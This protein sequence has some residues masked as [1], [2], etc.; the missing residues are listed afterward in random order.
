MVGVALAL[1]SGWRGAHAAEGP[2][3]GDWLVDADDAEFK[4]IKATDIVLGAKQRIVVPFDTAAKKARDESRFNRLLLLKLDPASLNEKTKAR[5][6]AGGGVLA[7]SA[8][9][10]HQA[11]DVN[12]WRA[13]EQR[14]LCFCHL[15]QFEPAD[16]ATVVSGPAPRPLP[17][18]PLQVDS[19]GR[20]AVAGE[21]SAPLGAI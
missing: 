15:S 4:P 8:I 19:D 6:E 7:Y 14:L 10:T 5:S 11:C 21:F 18:L 12:A 9:C 3:V 13:K 1:G 2:Q 17:S 16:G 20:L